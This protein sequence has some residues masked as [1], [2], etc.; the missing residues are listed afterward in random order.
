MEPTVSQI[1]QF[2]GRTLFMQVNI[3][4]VFNH[5]TTVRE[6]FY[7]R[8]RERPQITNKPFKIS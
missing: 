1:S 2:Y 8:E 5:L 6:L 4:E 7:A 3:Y